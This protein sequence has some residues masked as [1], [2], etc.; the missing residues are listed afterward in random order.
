MN[1]TARKL[2]VY[3][4]YGGAGA[5]LLTTMAAAIF[6]RGNQEES[7]SFFTHFISELGE[8]GVSSLA[9]VFNL[10]LI[11]SGIGMAAFFIGLAFYIRNWYTYIVSA[12]G[13]YAAVNASLVGVFPMN[14]IEPHTKVAMAFFQYGQ[15][16]LVLYTFYILLSRQGKLPRWTA[17]SALL[18]AAS[19]IA[20]LRVAGAEGLSEA[21]SSLAE[22][23]RPDFWWMPTLEWA[24]FFTLIAWVGLTAHAL[25]EK[26]PSE[27]S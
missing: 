12:I 11:L 19:F 24:V 7:F 25:R 5:V 21:E 20:F 14:N 8:E 6:Y 1:I 22:F 9:A 27:E 4:G 3:G 10:G 17:I 13:V 15:Y 16:T 18:S 26:E 23:V 2:T